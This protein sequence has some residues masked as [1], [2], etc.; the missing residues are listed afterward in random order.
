MAI[1]IDY[2]LDSELSIDGDGVTLTRQRRFTAESILTLY[3]SNRIP[4]SGSRH[5]D[6]SYF[7]LES[8]SCSIVGNVG[9]MRQILWTGQYRASGGSAAVNS[10]GGTRDPWDLG[11]TDFRDAP[12]STSAPLAKVYNP[13]TGGKFFLTNSAKCRYQLE[14][15]LYGRELTFTFAT[16]N[17]P[18][19]N[20]DPVV[21]ST[22]E[23]V[24]GVRIRAYYGLL[25]PLTCRRVV[26]YDDQGNVKRS[27]WEVGATIRIHPLG[28]RK[29]QLDVGTLA[30]DAKLDAAD[31][32]A[33]P[34]YRFSPWISGDAAAN[35]KTPPS[36]G[37]LAQVVAAKEVYATAVT[38]AKYGQNW[39]LAGTTNSESI[40]YYYQAFQNLPYT[41]VTEPLPLKDG[42]VYTDAMKDPETYPYNESRR[43][44][45]YMP[46]SW[47]QYNL[48][49]KVEG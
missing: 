1:T 43:Y 37:S 48:P 27:Y 35:T 11:A 45:E 33:E 29:T 25:M 22:T 26:E 9:G 10:T 39:T 36:F 34:I 3:E 15:D 5:P 2:T 44:L 7:R 14:H 23:T 20:S 41:E 46:A 32:K 28:W 47:A 30:F 42:F 8:G 13:T 19:I 49:A 17:A 12:F 16:R 18:M 38:R 24:A 21:N 40:A 31:R 4:Q 6:N